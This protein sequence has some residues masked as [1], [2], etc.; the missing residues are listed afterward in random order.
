MYG[1][2]LRQAEKENQED[3]MM[4]MEEEKKILPL[5]EDDFRIVRESKTESYYVDKSLMIRDFLREEKRVTLITRPRRFGKTLNMTM[6]RD[7]LDIN[8][9]SRD[10][11][12]GLA[13][14]DTKYADDINTVPVIYLSLKNCNGKN[15]EIMEAAVAEEMF[16]AYKNHAKHLKGVDEN[17][18]AYLRFFQTL[19][20]FRRVPKNEKGEDSVLRV[21]H[22]QKNLI[23]V[24]NSL[25]YLIEALHT[26]YQVRPI[27]LIDEYDNPI[28]EAHQLGFREEF[29]N[30]Y[31]TFLTTALKGN[32]HLKQALLTG[33]QRVAKESI[34]SKLN[35]PVVYNVLDE[36]YS[37]YFGL[38]EQETSTLL[39]YY[40]LKLDAEVKSYYDGYSFA[41]LEIYNPWSILNYAYWKIL[42]AYWLNTSTNALI[43]ESVINADFNFHRSFERLIKN[44]EVEISLNLEA[45]FA[46]LPRTDTLWGLFVNSGY[47]TVTQVD[48][49][50]NLF[51]VQI[52]NEEI[53]TEFRTIVSSYTKLS[54]QL[55]QEMLIAL[56]KGNM[57]DFFKIY[58]KLVLES[59]S[60]YDTK[61][62]AYHML[63]LGMV[64]HLRE[65]YEITSNIESGHGRSDIILKSKNHDRFHLVIEF[66]QGEAVEELKYKALKQI[67]DKKYYAGLTGEVLC[68]GIAHDKKRCELVHEIIDN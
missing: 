16:N 64:M 57:E 30:F 49:Q 61:E 62:N 65:L 45:A 17:D 27:V 68:I 56:I 34:F 28:I 53:I 60:Y 67:H 20:I 48:Y 50:L 24:Q 14:M 9:K 12:K 42:K 38:T 32:P 21:E 52:P 31:S 23:F 10:I 22:I 18:D 41:G 11:F 4:E 55:L 33:I 44:S 5:G 40:N 8:Q 26:F 3:L 51:T 59:T 39:N 2:L 13:I 47:L 7:F 63:M 43:K 36:Y 1:I 25:S 6:L 19:E 15:V 46:E 54:S 58:Q 66:K 35:N 29:T 37:S